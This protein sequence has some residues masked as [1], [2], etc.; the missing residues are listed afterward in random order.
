ML[1]L[2]KRGHLSSK[3]AYRLA[4]SDFRVDFQRYLSDL[5][6]RPIQDLQALIGF[7]LALSDE[8]LPP[9]MAFPYS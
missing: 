2:S 5:E 7:K 1:I 4:E 6:Y 9:G 3:G 8:E